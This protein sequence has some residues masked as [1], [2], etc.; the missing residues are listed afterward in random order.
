M[1]VKSG[2]HKE[3]ADKVVKDTRRGEAIDAQG[4]QKGLGAPTSMGDR[5][6][7]PSTLATPAAQR[8]HIGLDPGLVDEDKPGRIEAALPRLPAFSA[9][10]DISS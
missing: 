3:P 4:G 1:R 9:A 8:G 6:R 2:N 7:H 10:G 5:G